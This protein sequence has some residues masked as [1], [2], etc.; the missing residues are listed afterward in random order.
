[1]RRPRCPAT[2]ADQSY[3][4]S[5]CLVQ[6]AVQFTKRNLT[7][8]DIVKRHGPTLG[9]GIP[10]QLQ[11][12]TIS[13][14][15]PGLTENC[16]RGTDA[17]VAHDQRSFCGAHGAQHRTPSYETLSKHGPPNHCLMIMTETVH[18]PTMQAVACLETIPI[19]HCKG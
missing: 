18:A 11:I 15:R 10:G 9:N 13:C 2:H 5:T 12:Q 14:L 6:R 16:L 4:L 1:M 19:V 3:D 8:R 7:H 17:K